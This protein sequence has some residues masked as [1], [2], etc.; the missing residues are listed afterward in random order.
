MWL[1]RLKRYLIGASFPLSFRQ[2][3]LISFLSIILL[4]GGAL[5]RALVVVETLKEEN[6]QYPVKA[7]EIVE[8]VRELQ[9]LTVNLERDARQYLVLN[10]PGLRKE[11]KEIWRKSR[12]VT[13]TL[14]PIF[15]EKLLPLTESWQALT[16]KTLTPL[17][18]ATDAKNINQAN[19]FAAFRQLGEINQKISLESKNYLTQRNQALIDDFERQ[20]HS[21]IWLGISA[22]TVAAALALVLGIWLAWSFE[23]LDVAIDKLGSRRPDIPITIGGPTDMR[24]LGQ[25]IDWLRQ[26]LATLE[27]DKLLFL[28]HVS[29]ELKTPLANLR[30]GIALLEDQITG[31]LTGNQKEII[32]ILRENAIAL[33]HQIE[34]L[35]QYNAVAFDSRRLERRNLDL[36]DLLEEVVSRQRLQ[37]QSRNIEV[38]VEGEV[39]KT[40]ADPAKMEVAVG[41]LL[42]NAIR[43]SPDEGRIRFRLSRGPHSI[44]IDCIDSGP[45]IDPSDQ[46][47]IF[48]PFY[49]GIRQPPGARKGSGI[50][51]SIVKELIEAHGGTVTLLSGS[52]GAHFRIEIPDESN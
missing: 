46:D 5:T 34:G 36:R 7:L 50:G 18:Q 23:Q 26:R 12:V 29:H 10:D 43:F 51:L 16:E 47:K 42:S 49:Q 2:L 11:L 38:V 19:V 40:S 3:L 15:P 31:Y 17:L 35:L 20:R 27:A 25:R 33:Q 21:L 14:G 39:L 22:A 4:L 24:Q 37:F 28:R 1:T 6:R 45:G 13:A 48:N 32:V 8:N 9:D 44:L 41:N 52:G 30:E